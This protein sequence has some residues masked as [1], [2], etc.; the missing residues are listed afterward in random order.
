MST[1]TS[2]PPRP[3]SGA[4]RRRAAA[5]KKAHGGARNPAVLIGGVVAVVVLALVVALVAGGG[6]D[7]S[8]ADESDATAAFSETRPV[9]VVGEPLPDFEQTAGDAAV[10]LTAPTLQ[11]RLFN[12][13]GLSLPVQGRPTLLVYLAHWCPH[14]QK[15]VPLLTDWEAAG[16]VPDGVEIFGIAT[17]TDDAAVNYPPSEWLEREEFPFAVLADSEASEAGAAMGVTGYPAFV[18]VDAAG[19][20]AWRTSGEVPIDELQALIEGTLTAA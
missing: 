6:D 16:G 3:G 2:I 14:C 7:A 15:E 11:G 19:K 8:T 12:G 18:M 5:K 17:A 4:A 10:G 9:T 20:V 13:V 1:D